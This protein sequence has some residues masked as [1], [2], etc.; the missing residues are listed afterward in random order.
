MKSR[1]THAI[2]RTVVIA[3]STGLGLI[4]IVLNP[5]LW[6]V[7]PVGAA[8]GV[9]IWFPEMMLRVLGFLAVI[10]APIAIIA[11]LVSV[12][13]SEDNEHGSGPD[14]PRTLPSTSFGEPEPMPSSEGPD[15]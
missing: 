11:A 9:M 2:G 6:W 1:D 8:V 4:L 13:G 15:E 14:P 12:L 3:V 10:A 5:L 7:L